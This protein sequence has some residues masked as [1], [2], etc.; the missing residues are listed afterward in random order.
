MIYGILL[1]VNNLI[2]FNIGKYLM[3]QACHLFA[4]SLLSSTLI[5]CGGGGSDSV[6]TKPTPTNSPPVLTVID[7]Q[8]TFYKTPITI[9]VHA[10]DSDGDVLTY[11]ATSSDQNVKLSWN[12]NNLITSPS[13]GFYGRVDITVSVSDGSLSDSSTFLME[14]LQTSIPPAPSLEKSQLSTPPTVPSV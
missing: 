13:E 11:S 4:V 1:Y 10:N 3:N 9:V 12:N 5:A 2:D 7:T 6:E 14:V 8:N